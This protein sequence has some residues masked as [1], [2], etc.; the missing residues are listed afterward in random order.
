ML[1]ALLQAIA[2]EDLLRRMLQEECF[3]WEALELPQIE[4]GRITNDSREEVLP[5]ELPRISFQLKFLNKSF[6]T[7]VT[8]TFSDYTFF[9]KKALF[10]PS[11]KTLT[12][13]RF[14]YQNLKYF[15]RKSF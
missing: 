3:N 13:S 15:L 10:K 8:F 4:K 1:H 9:C 6:T 5:L 12:F 2:V 14:Q 11:I 7:K